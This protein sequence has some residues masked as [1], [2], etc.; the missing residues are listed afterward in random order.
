MGCQKNIARKIIDKGANYGLALKGNQSGLHEDVKALFA[1]FQLKDFA[2]DHYHKTE[3]NCHGRYEIRQC[4]TI[5]D[6]NA[7]ADLQN[8]AAW[9]GLQSVVRVRA[10]RYS[11]HQV[12]VE[13]RYFISSLPGEAQHL[14]QAVRGHWSIENSLHWVLDIAFAEDECR[15]RKGHGAQNFAVLR[16]IALNLLKQETT[17]KSGIKAKR[18]K[19][20]RN[21]DYL[22]KVLAG[23]T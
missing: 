16:H 20:G 6:P 18:K 2:P 3:E 4:W 15:I 23:F 10:E 1:K 5:S 22:L 12:S 21:E 17:V 9:T 14:L 13:D 8:L 11:D 19:A 7:L